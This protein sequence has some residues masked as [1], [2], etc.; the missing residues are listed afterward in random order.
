MK[1]KGPTDVSLSYPY[2]DGTKVI[3][4]GGKALFITKDGKELENIPDGK[5][6]SQLYSYGFVNTEESV[7]R[8]TV[9]EG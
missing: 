4:K 1:L 3:T 8:K 5:V 7:E 9:K 2:D 6:P